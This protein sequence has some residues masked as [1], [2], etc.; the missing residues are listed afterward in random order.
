MRCYFISHLSLILPLWNWLK[1]GPNESQFNLSLNSDFGSSVGQNET[2]IRTR[3]R[4]TTTDEPRAGGVRIALP[5]HFRM[6]A[7]AR[8]GRR[9]T[10]KIPSPVQSDAD[11]EIACVLEIYLFAALCMCCAHITSTSLFSSRDVLVLNFKIREPLVEG[12]WPFILIL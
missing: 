6:I 4:R 11:G 10:K 2:Q 3:N 9:R 5:L 7:S 12:V 1:S 8:E